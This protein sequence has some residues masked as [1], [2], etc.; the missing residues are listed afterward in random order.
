MKKK[1]RS[2]NYLENTL[3][4]AF[5]DHRATLTYFTKDLRARAFLI[6]LTLALRPH[7][8]AVGKMRLTLARISGRSTVTICGQLI[9]G[10]RVLECQMLTH[11]NAQRGFSFRDC[12]ELCCNNRS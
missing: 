3:T 10:R 2:T 5:L 11:I 4:T 9:C 12:I 1:Q 8:L 7:S 6:L